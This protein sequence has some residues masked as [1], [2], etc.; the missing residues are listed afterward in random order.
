MSTEFKDAYAVEHVKL[1]R[2][3]LWTRYLRA[4]A[5]ERPLSHE[6]RMRDARVSKDI[7]HHAFYPP[8]VLRRIVKG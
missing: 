2:D 8:D 5:S 7:Y 1:F 6:D 4:V 3:G